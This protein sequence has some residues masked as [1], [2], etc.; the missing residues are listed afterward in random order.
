MFRDPT[1]KEAGYKSF[2]LDGWNSWHNK[3]RL[4]EHVGGVSS[5]HNIAKKKCEDLLHKAQHIDVALHKQLET[6]KNAYF[7]RLNGAIDTARLLLKQE[8]PFRGHDESNT[9]YNRGNYREV[10]LETSKRS[11]I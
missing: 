9:S 5:L 2:V 1:K 8:L 6:S 11:R 10:E 4:K 3:E 7:V